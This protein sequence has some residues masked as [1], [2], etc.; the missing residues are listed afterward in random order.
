VFLPYS[1]DATMTPNHPF[2]PQGST[3]QIPPNAV[4]AKGTLARRL[5][6][7]AATRGLYLSRLTSLLDTAWDETA[8]NHEID[9]MTLLLAPL[10]DKGDGV[11][12]AVD[13]V[14]SFVMTR[15][16]VIDDELGLGTPNWQYPP[17]GDPCLMTIGTASGT[18]DTTWGTINS[19]TPFM[20]GSGTIML[21]ESG[22]TIALSQIGAEA[23]P[24]PNP[25]PG[26]PEG[27]HPVVQMIGQRTDGRFNVVAF[28][29]YP[30]LFLPASTVKLDLFSA[31]G[32]VY[33]F[34][35]STM[36]ATQDGFVIG[37]GS[38]DERRGGDREL[39]RQ[40]RHVE[41]VAVLSMG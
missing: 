3:L 21:V 16:Q 35:P 33:T 29:M 2:G 10:A 8:L 1:A 27:P 24:D 15:R 32:A 41:S 17:P 12:A 37:S 5:Y 6:L 40:R 23:G 13:Q 18:F 39:Q 26:A 14:R 38:N 25:T 31:Y 11:A 22:S 20:T 28:S 34:D 4:A 36:G 19:P 7:D 30:A 9:R